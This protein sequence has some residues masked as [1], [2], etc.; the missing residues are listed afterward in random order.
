MIK[1]TKTREI[2]SFHVT[3]LAPTAVPLGFPPRKNLPP[4]IFSRV[5]K[6]RRNSERRQSEDRRPPPVTAVNRHELA[7]AAASSTRHDQRAT[8][9]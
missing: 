1:K 6:H 5:L 9:G 2:Q 3:L 7:A 8:N 4:Q